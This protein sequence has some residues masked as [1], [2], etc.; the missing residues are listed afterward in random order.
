[1]PFYLVCDV[2]KSMTHQMPVLNEALQGLRNEIATNPV[3]DDVARICV[4]VFS[5]IAQVVIPLGQPSE[6]AVPALSVQFGTNYGNAFRQLTRRIDYDTSVLK[7]QGHKVYR[8]CVFFLTDG[9]PQD[10]DWEESFR[11]TLTY[12][13]ATGQG[14]KGHPVFVPVGFRQAQ[15]AILAKLAYP[16]QRGKWYID[17]NTN[18]AEAIRELLDVIKKTIITS[19]LSSLTEP[20]VTPVAPS[21]RNIQQGDYDPDYV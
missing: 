4:M 10:R 2:S 6:M 12:D 3:V 13:R 1:M 15:P 5:D 18:Y 11:S 7:K 8:P 16:A 9:E 19:G 20:V 17:R 14:M 21:N